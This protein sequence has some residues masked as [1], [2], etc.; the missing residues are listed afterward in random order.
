MKHH[1]LF[2]FSL[3]FFTF[4]TYAQH[5]IQSRVFDENNGEAL[6]AIVVRLLN[7]KDSSMV[8]G[9]QTDVRGSFILN[10][11]KP[12]DY[13]LLLNSIGYH[14]YKLDVKMENKNLILKNIQMKEDSKLLSEV[15]IRGT[16]A[17]M[18]VR[19][20]TLEYNA[21]AFKTAENAIVEDLLKRLPGVEVS[22]EGKITVNGEEI[23]KI[24]V[25]GKKFFDGDIEMTTKNLPADMV[26][27]IQVL[28]EKSEMAKLTGFEDDETERIINLTLR[29]NRRIGLSSNMNG[30]IGMDTEN[31]LRYNLNGMAN[32]MQ[33]N[34]QTGITIGANNINE[35][36]S[37]RGRGGGGGNGVTSSQSFGVTNNTIL[38]PKLKLGG[39]G[40]FNHSLN[41]SETDSYKLSYMKDSTYTDSTSTVSHNGRYNGNIRLEIE[42]KPD[43]MNTFIIQPSATYTRSYNDNDHNFVYYVEDD[44]TSV[45]NSMNYGTGT[46]INGRLN[47]IY[48]RKFQKQGR[49][50]TS[51]LNTNFSQNDDESFNYSYRS[52]IENDT[53]DQYTTNKSNQ[54]GFNGRISFVE[55]LWNVQNLLE[56]SV[57]FRANINTSEKNQYEN[58]DKIRLNDFD[59][60][61]ANSSKE[62]YIERN[63]EYSNNYKN[64]F[65][66][67]IAE[68]NYRH[69]KESYTLT[70]GIKAEPSQTY[71][72]TTYGNGETRDVVNEVFNFSPTGRFQYNFAKKKFIRIDYRGETDQPSI[73]QMQPVKNNSNLMSETVGNPILNPS[74][75][76]RFRFFYSSSDPIRFSSFNTS[77]TINTVKDA[78]ITNTIYDNTGKRYNQTVN[79]DK[80]PF[81][82][83][84]N[85]MYNTPLVQK[86]LHFNTRTNLGFR[87]VYG[88]SRRGLETIDT[89]KMV[90]FPHDYLGDLSATKE[91]NASENISLTFTHDIIEFGVRGNVNYRKTENNLRA[92]NTEI[93]N[94][95]GSS[96]FVL[97]LPYNINI[98]SDINY[99][100]RTTNQG[101]SN[102]D[103]NE[104][105]WNASIDKTLFKN[106]GVLSLKW[107]DILQQR[108]NIRESV[109]D[110]Y[111][112]YSSYNTLTSYF[113]VS[114]SY[115][116][117]RF[118]G[119]SN[120]NSEEPQQENIR[121]RPRDG[122]GGGDR[123]GPPS[124]GMF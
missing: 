24:R 96:N 75:S 111:I 49:T 107:H 124:G 60:Y 57:S 112:Q 32:V 88:Y 26:E 20:D 87:Q 48:N 68:L 50:L 41:K 5:S 56:A 11:V 30:G 10:N 100:T 4:S 104:L 73:N 78:F 54:F 98:S 39:D 123:S 22:S 65:F 27:K 101:Y 16:A 89:E 51:R 110:N 31:N 102:F 103:R 40:S 8:Q 108:L 29:P 84:F 95:T 76:H 91:Y 118:G 63:E 12:G 83:N 14:E 97:H 120:S 36:R 66:R 93:W 115:K 2:Y 18:I 13:Y 52:G 33:G 46:N 47:V 6:E 99:T 117:N 25:D 116:I 77:L 70:L 55:P 62:Q 15:E 38:N 105:I 17:Q 90:E 44:T 81:N 43:S 45:G 19:G 7:S 37:S 59:Y 79:S 3:F 85:L 86:R 64:H 80:M 23:T 114:F 119:R 9:V 72:Y 35:S 94:W 71:S 34:S 67:E 69:I 74:F 42:W 61:Y 82:G 109:G 58:S 21:T 1:F 113:L 122:G 28:E 53:I 121:M 92:Q 106:K